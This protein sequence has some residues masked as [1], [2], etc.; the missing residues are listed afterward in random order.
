MTFLPCFTQSL[1]PSC[2]HVKFMLFI[3][4]SE[5]QTQL[6]FETFDDAGT[7][8]QDLCPVCTLQFAIK[9]VF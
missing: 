9:K 5:L 7:R 1:G 6:I 4:S 3:P 2:Y 8:K